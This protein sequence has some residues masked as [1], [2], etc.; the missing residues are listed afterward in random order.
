[1]LGKGEQTQE[2][3]FLLASLG[4]DA[5]DAVP[6][7]SQ[8]LRSGEPLTR[9]LAGAALM[10]IDPGHSSAARVVKESLS[11]LGEYMVTIQDEERLL[12]LIDVFGRLGRMDKLPLHGFSMKIRDLPLAQEFLL[13]ADSLA[14]SYITRRRPALPECKGEYP[15]CQ[16]C[17][18][19]GNIGGFL[20]LTKACDV[21]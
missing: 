18:R 1:M 15:S 13:S 17:I 16:T 21:Q 3:I 20:S 5:K 10:R 7:L 8:L 12:F 14:W 11:A 2:A 4:A 6:A 9:G 19:R